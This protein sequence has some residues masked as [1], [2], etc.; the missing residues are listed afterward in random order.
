MKCPNCQSDNEETHKFCRNCGTR[1]GMVCPECGIVVLPSDRFCI[2]CGIEFKSRELPQKIQEELLSERKHVTALFA[3][4]SGYTALGERLDPEELKDIIGPLISEMANVVIKYEGSVEKFAGDQIM[5]LFGFPRAHEDDPVRAVRTAI[6][7]HRVAGEISQKVEAAIGQPL[8]IHIGINS[9]LAVTGQADFHHVTKHVA[10][11]AINVASRLC[12]LAG[13]GETLVGH[14]TY[15]QAVAFFSFEALKPVMVKGKT[16]AIQIYRLVAPKES[17]CRTH[18]VSGLRAELIGRGN[19]LAV[20]AKAVNRLFEG[21]P[22]FIVICGEAGTGKSRLIEEFKA[23]LD[24]KVINWIEGRAY[25]YTQNISYYPLINLINRELGIEESDTPEDVAKKL[26]ARVGELVGAREDVTSYLGSLLSLN[27]PETT[28]VSPEF[29]KARLYHA[30]QAILQAQT[31][32][33]PT[34]ICLEDL[35]WSDT[36]FLDFVRFTHIQQRATA[37]TLCTYRPP[38]KLFSGQEINLLR[39]GYQEIRLQDLSL[40]DTHRMVESILKTESIPEELR[41]YIQEKVGGN[42]FYLEEMLN[43]LVESGTLLCRQGHWR[44]ARAIKDSDIPPTVHAVVTGRIDRLEGPAKHLLQEASVIGRTVP[45]EILKRVTEYPEILDESLA[46]LERLDLIRPPT[47]LEQ[48]YYFK[49]ALIQEVVYGSLLKKD[50]QAMHERI[51][52]LMEQ[53]FQDRLPEIFETLSFHFRQSEN[54]QKALDYL[55]ESGRKNLGKYATQESHHYYQEAFQILQNI[56]GDGQAGKKRLVDFLNEWAEVYYY[57]GDYKGFTALLL[58]HLELAESTQD[59]ARLGIYYGWLGF[60]LFGSGKVRDSY[61]YSSK[62]LQLGEETNS[63]PIMGLAY[64]NLTW[65][66]AELKLLDQGIQYGIEAEKIAGLYKLEPM[67]FF[68]SLGGMGMIYLFK[69]NSDKDFE[70]G[71]KLLEYGE[72]HSNL[73]SIVVGHI[74]TGYGHYITGDFA[75][76]VACSKKAIELLNDPL[77]SEWPKLF[78]SVCYLVNGQIKEAEEVIQEIL[79]FCKNLGIGYIVT[80]AQVLQGAVLVAKGKFSRGIKMLEKDLGIFVDNG[81][82]FSLYYLE[83]VAAETYFRIAMREGTIDL[84]NVMKNL[85]FLLAKL[86]GARRR[87]E[88]YLNKIIQV[89]CEVESQ[90]FVHGQ[91]LLNLGLLH[92]L[93]KKPLLARECFTKSIQILE[94]CSST[95]SLQ[96][97]QEA[98]ASVC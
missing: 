5:A 60:A 49:H 76:A 32:K 93:N 11:D 98:L 44:L 56:L 81:R 94:H 19:E 63:Y 41:R 53:V 8:S 77:F 16:K 70:I 64:A 31:Q 61:E 88:S 86:P 45:Y 67:I 54:S 52:L 66:C 65:A 35:H 34:I 75:Q 51:G 58:N 73:R 30:V 24:L 68:Q 12:S 21:S 43:S 20:L 79:P 28:G 22:S 96:R 69:G 83:N 7:I 40:A 4:I 25:N 17:L 89:G 1:L 72:R 29:W 50:R 91:A 55:I 85:G 2:E 14:D 37:I 84:I 10:G 23:T 42:P 80:V 71:R 18:R 74:I 15:T 57:R 3:D 36:S 87:A 26:E 95:T 90:A 82:F 62:A 33:A 97:A 13:A 59:K 78:L 6:E 27:Y 38:L 92:R 46:E 39:E 48:D 9:G 47:Q